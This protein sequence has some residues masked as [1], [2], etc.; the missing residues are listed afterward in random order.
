MSKAEFEAAIKKLK[1]ASFL[2]FMIPGMP[3]IYYGDEIGTEGYEDPFC[4]GYFDWT[5]LENNSLLEFFRALCGIKN[6]YEPIIKGDIS[7][8]KNDGGVLIFTRQYKNKKMQVYL[9]FNYLNVNTILSENFKSSLYALFMFSSL[10][11]FLTS[12]SGTEYNADRY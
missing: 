7:F 9:H 2:Q 6:K 5:R 8:I 10:N 3:S 1:V 12:R 4:R 11:L